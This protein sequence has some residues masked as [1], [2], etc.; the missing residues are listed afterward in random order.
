MKHLLIAIA[1]TLCLC[2]MGWAQC[3]K[4]TI[5]EDDP[6]FKG[7]FHGRVIQLPPEWKLIPLENL[8]KPQPPARPKPC[9]WQYKTVPE[10]ELESWLNKGWT[11]EAAYSEVVQNSGATDYATRMG[12][13]INK[14]I[15]KRRMCP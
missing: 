2:G 14:A 8:P 3:N 12:F 7:L 1:L 11:F 6:C 9:S 4:I 5:P 13:T 15:I 10:Q